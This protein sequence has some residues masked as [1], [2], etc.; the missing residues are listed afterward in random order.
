LANDG[1][2]A[3]AVGAAGFGTAFGAPGA[4][5]MTW[6]GDDTD[7]NEANCSRRRALSCFVM[8]LTSA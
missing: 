5:T 6:G 3:A 1:Y 4:G 7:I 8:D 2:C